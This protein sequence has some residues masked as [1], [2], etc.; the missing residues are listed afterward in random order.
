MKSDS[1]LKKALI[2]IYYFLWENFIRI[3]NGMLKTT[4]SNA[5][6]IPI[7][8]NNRNRFTFL[9]QMIDALNEKGYHNIYI[10]DNNSSYQPLL[11]YYD[12]IPHKVFR[13]KENVGFLSLWKMGIY[14][15]FENNYFVYS[16]SDV[17]PTEYCPNDFLQIFLNRMKADPSLMK[18]GLSLK[19][20]DLPD[21][22]KNKQEVIEWES[23]YFKNE[24]DDLFYLANVDTT[25]ALYRPYMRGGASR[26]KMFR[27]KSPMEAYHMPWYNDSSNLSEEEIFYINNAKTSTHWTAK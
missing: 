15:E 18:I 25:F 4:Y 16:D 20:D 10:I 1:L 9:K 23:Q 14:K 12:R 6:D 21:Q 2:P 8:I 19:I 3:R 7:I 22:F 13:L 5:F 27:S 17:V 26:L 24:I 11:A